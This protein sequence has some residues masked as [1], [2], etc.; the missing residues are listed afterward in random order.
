M[1]SLLCEFV[2]DSSSVVSSQ[3]TFDNTCIYM[4]SLQCEFVHVACSLISFKSPFHN[5]YMYTTSFLCEMQADNR[6]KNWPQC[7]HTICLPK[8]NKTNIK[9]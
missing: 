8:E 3:S 6:F 4:A 5:T 9:I 7:L 2:H 1:A